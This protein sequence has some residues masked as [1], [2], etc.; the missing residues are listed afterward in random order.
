MRLA[1]ALVLV[2]SLLIAGCASP[3]LGASAPQPAPTGPDGVFSATDAFP[4]DYSTLKPVMAHKGAFK[5]GEQKVT[6]VKSTLDGADI[7]IYVMR[8]DTTQKVPVVLDAGPYFPP[9]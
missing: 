6:L 2:A 4:G 8:P 3:L 9:L 7:Q 1:G 5:L